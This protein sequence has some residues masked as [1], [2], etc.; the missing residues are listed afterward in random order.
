MS[1]TFSLLNDL[2]LAVFDF[3]LGWLLWLPR[4]AA[5]VAVGVLT[6][7]VMTL[8]RVAATNQDRLRRAAADQRRLKLL[9]RQARAAKDVD[10]LGRLKTTQSQ[11]QWLKLKAELGPLLVVLV[12]I[13][14]LA[15]WAYQRLGYYPP[16]GDEVLQF[17]AYLPLSADEDVI[18]LVPQPGVHAVNGWV[19]SVR[20]QTPE[21]TRWDRFWATVTFRTAEETPTDAEAIWHLQ[22]APRPEPYRLCVRWREYTFVHELLVGQSRYLPPLSVS[23]DAGEIRPGVPIMT[24]V[25][26][27]PVTLLGIPG[28]DPWLPGWLVG[29][30]VVTLPLVPALRRLLGVY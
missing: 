11:V 17:K 21:V 6:A 1:E 14:L 18:H 27:R 3:A 13:A 5:V 2:I 26:L 22:V 8:A 20:R 25:L 10:W 30:L 23:A 16:R 4:W 15:T 19:Q 24:E 12:P 29:Y 7:A 28:I 9:L